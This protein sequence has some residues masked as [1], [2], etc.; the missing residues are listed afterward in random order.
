MFTFSVAN[1]RVCGWYSCGSDRSAGVAIL[2][3]K[4][5]G[6]LIKHHSDVNGRWITLLCDNEPSQIVITKSQ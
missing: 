4:F 6:N 5:Q 3:G 2:Q 1:S